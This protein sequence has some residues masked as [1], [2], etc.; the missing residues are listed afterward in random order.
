MVFLKLLNENGYNGVYTYAK[1]VIKITNLDL[2][3]YDIIDYVECGIR[4]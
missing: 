1:C 2:Q 4:R 3:K